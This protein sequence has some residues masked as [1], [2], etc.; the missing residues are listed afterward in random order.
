MKMIVVYV[1][2]L[3]NSASLKQFCNALEEVQRVL[4]VIIAMIKPRP[5]P[6]FK[7]PCCWTSMI[8]VEFF[9]HGRVPG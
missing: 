5:R 3:T 1:A 6:A 9:R 4:Q 7:C 2:L 8:V